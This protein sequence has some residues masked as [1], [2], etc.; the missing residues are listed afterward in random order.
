MPRVMLTY[1]G[2]PYG[3]EDTYARP[4]PL[5]AV[6]VEAAPDV[7]VISR[8]PSFT[9]KA[10]AIFQVGRCRSPV[11]RPVLK[12]PWVSTLETKM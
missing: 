1:S 2:W 4:A 9:E 11:S 3:M 5:K 8:A 10:A 12:P 6:A 7:A